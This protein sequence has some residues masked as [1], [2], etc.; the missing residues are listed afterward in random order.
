MAN[1]EI[2]FFDCVEPRSFIKVYSDDEN[3][4]EKLEK[5]VIKIIGF[6]SISLTLHPQSNHPSSQISLWAT[7]A[8][9]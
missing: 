3:G 6:F 4:D 2:K 9:N 7:T 5:K 1:F 8:G